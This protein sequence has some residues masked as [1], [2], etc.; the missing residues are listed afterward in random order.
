MFDYSNK[1]Q[2]ML[3]TLCSEEVVPVFMG[4]AC[5]TCNNT[6]CIA[7]DVKSKTCPF[8]RTRISWGKR[9]RRATSEQYSH[10]LVHFKNQENAQI[11]RYVYAKC[12]FKQLI[13]DSPEAYQILRE[14]DD[15]EDLFNLMVIAR[16]YVYGSAIATKNI[17]DINF[18]L[19]F[20]ED[21]Y[22]RLEQPDHP[23]IQ[24]GLSLDT[25]EELLFESEEE[26]TEERKEWKNVTRA[27]KAT[28]RQQMRLT[29]YPKNQR[30]IRRRPHYR[31]KC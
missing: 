17:D 25:V 12:L 7:C 22:D 10:Y 21:L 16:D 26:T 3:C 29:K 8:C 31:M 24:L 20:I 14:L 28:H 15:D 5:E 18:L 1:I 4:V 23:R 6:C 11:Q 30:S 9:F 2:P 13:Q 19:E 27:T